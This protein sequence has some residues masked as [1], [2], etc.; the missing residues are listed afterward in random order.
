MPKEYGEAR[1]KQ[2][3]YYEQQAASYSSRHVQPD[4]AHSIAL[5]F[6]AALIG[7]AAPPIV[8]DVGAGT[9][10]AASALGTTLP[11]AR[12][13]STDPIAELLCQG[14]GPRLLALGERL[15]I[16]HASVDYALALGVMHHVQS[17]Q[18]V[19]AEMMRV[20]RRGIFISDNNRFGVGSPLARRAKRLLGACH[21]LGAYDLLR[22]HGRGYAESEGD[23]VSFPFGIYDLYG[24]LASW[25][26]RI[27]VIP[28]SGIA[29]RRSPTMFAGSHLLLCAL[30]ED[31]GE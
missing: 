11:A 29:P 23:G 14:A 10:R 17:P 19:I 31:P 12:V 1:Q 18:R 8:L 28:T 26:H 15:P 9:G 21:L 2:A 13:I 16:H 7:S 4:D 24:Q 25:A 22:T 30:R 3:A 20:S 27:F 6:I 5:R